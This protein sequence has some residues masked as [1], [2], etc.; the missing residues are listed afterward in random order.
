LTENS[1]D[2]MM[3][4]KL[5]QEQMKSIGLP[6]FSRIC[7]FYA[8]DKQHPFAGEDLCEKLMNWVIRLELGYLPKTSLSL[9]CG[10]MR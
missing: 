3:P 2:G 4:R 5:I 10:I 9:R 7:E 8:D 1:A 6:K